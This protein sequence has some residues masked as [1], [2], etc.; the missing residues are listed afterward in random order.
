[1]MVF[2]LGY[3][4]SLSAQEPITGCPKI[5]F[6]SSQGTDTTCDES[7]KKVGF[8]LSNK[9]MIKY[10]NKA[11]KYSHTDSSTYAAITADTRASRQE[12][13]FY[14]FALN[15]KLAGNH[16]WGG[17]LEMKVYLKSKWSTGIFLGIAGRGITDTFTFSIARPVVSYVETGWVNQY[18]IIQKDRLRIGLQLATNFGFA[19]LRDKAQKVRERTRYGYRDLPKK[20]AVNPYYIAAPGLDIS[21]K[22]KSISNAPDIFITANSKYR[23]AIGN[24]HFGPKDAFLGPLFSIGISLIGYSDE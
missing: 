12:I 16:L 3:T 10:Q 1:M 9:V 17:G 6:Y 4:C 22:V 14:I 5:I 24:W 7:V 13:S 19:E 15:T 2:V 20:V 8:T 23:L 18:D 11:K 21:L